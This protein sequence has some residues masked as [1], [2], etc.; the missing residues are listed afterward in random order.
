[1]FRVCILDF[2][3]SWDAYLPLAEFAYNN[4]FEYSIHMDPYET[5]YGRRCRSPI[6][7]FKVG[8]ANVLE[9]DLVQK[10]MDKV[11]LIRQNCSQLK[12]DKSL[13][14]IREEEI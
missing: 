13:M 11:R 7:W 4:S 12:A 5:L 2:G 1:M 8:E 10:A 14:W 9:P 3:G 6:R